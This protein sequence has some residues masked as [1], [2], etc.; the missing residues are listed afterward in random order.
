MSWKDRDKKSKE[1]VEL[2][3]TFLDETK[4]AIK[5][6]TGTGLRIWVPKSL[7][8]ELNNLNK[9]QLIDILVEEWFAFKEGLI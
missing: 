3:V 2:S 4:Q 8:G 9:G 5:V 7:C 6:E 1:K